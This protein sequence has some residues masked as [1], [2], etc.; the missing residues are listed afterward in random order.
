MP[1]KWFIC[2]PD[3]KTIEVDKCLSQRGCRLG[4]RCS[5]I[6][7]LRKAAQERPW[8]RV[9]P[10]QAG[11]GPRVTYL[12]QVC[13]Y[14]IDPYDMAFAVIGQGSHG[15]LSTW[16]LTRG[17]ISEEGFSDDLIKG[18]PDLLE[19]D[20]EE[21]GFHILYDY[22]TS[23]SYK[24]RLALG[25]T[26]DTDNPKL[27]KNNQPLKHT[28]GYKRGKIKYHDKIDREFAK[29]NILDWSLQLNRYR[30]V[31]EHYDYPVSRMICQAIPRDGNTW[32]ANNRGIMENVYLIKIPR[33]DDKYV[34][35]FYAT[36]QEDHERAFESNVP[37]MCSAWE[38]WDG[39]RCKGFCPIK[40]YC[41]NMEKDGAIYKP[42][43][44]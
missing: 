9:T 27:G 16:Y 39:R 29:K 26:E 38:K 14:A 44:E 22:K 18:I 31:V 13:D 2:P 3:K 21:I 41:D 34:L 4:E 19:P 37:R 20:E 30:I 11:T 36:L 15:K 10:S 5:T 17:F 23:G 35:D 28:S 32:I 8:K 12:K 25:L 33:L 24:V 7:Y 42:V 40:S 1:V 6:P 43:G